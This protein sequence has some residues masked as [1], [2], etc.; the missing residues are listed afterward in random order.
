MLTRDELP[1]VLGGRAIRPAGP[2]EWPMPDSG[3]ERMLA[4]AYADGNW[5]RYH[6]P[7][8]EQFSEFLAAY[9]AIPHVHLCASGTAAVEFALRGVGISSGDEVLLAAYEFKANLQ[10]LFALGVSPV[11]VDVRPDD[12]NL[13]VSQLEKAISSKTKAVLVSH[14]HGGVVD[15]PAVMSIAQ[16]HGLAVVEDACQMPGATIA[17]RRAG[18]W[19]DAGILSFGGSKLTTAGRGGAVLTHRDD[20]AQLLPQWEALNER[21]ARRTRAAVF[22]RDALRS[23]RG[24]TS[25]AV[26][27]VMGTE[28]G[29]YKLGFQYEADAFQGLS[30]DHFA[31]AIRAEGIA[32]DPGFRSLHKTHAQ[33]RYRTSDNL[34]EADR[35]DAGILTLHHPILLG[36]ETD[37]QE[38]PAAIEKIR[39]ASGQ[40]VARPVC[41]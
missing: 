13:D 12:W 11:L 3:V 35:A 25:F 37:L 19:G 27:S 32:L 20:V 6:G 2:P 33:R 18:T 30:R 14:L 15:M 31:A 8:V 1:A 40:L 16:V 26:P 38:V 17:G 39:H 41:H 34:P 36:T 28:P 4:R 5:G 10:N 24:L 7:Y 23:T 22:L 21:N 29:Y 9:H